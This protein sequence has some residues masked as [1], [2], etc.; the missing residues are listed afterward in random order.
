VSA[1]L[2]AGQKLLYSADWMRPTTDVS[3]NPI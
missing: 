3:V 1:C 2:K